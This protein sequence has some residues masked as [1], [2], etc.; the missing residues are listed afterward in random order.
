[1]VRA[2][3]DLFRSA[4][5]RPDDL[6]FPLGRMERRGLEL[7]GAGR[8]S[9]DAAVD[10]LVGEAPLAP[11]T[12]WAVVGERFDFRRRRHAQLT[13]RVRAIMSWRVVFSLVKSA[14]M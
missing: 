6:R 12:L 14:G 5:R 7:A 8:A 10:R 9:H 11:G 3:I 4:V 2:R 13:T 1:M